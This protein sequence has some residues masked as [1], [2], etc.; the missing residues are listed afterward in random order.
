[1]LLTVP[2]SQLACQA[3]QI[4]KKGFRPS[5]VVTYSFIGLWGNEKAC[6]E[7]ALS[8]WSAANAWTGLNVTFQRV[9]PGSAPA[10]TLVKTFLSGQAAGN[11][12]QPTV[13]AFDG[14]IIG[15]SAQFTTDRSLLESCEG[16][17]KVALHEIGHSMGLADAFGTSGTSVMN[18]MSGKD[19]V[20]NS[21]AANVTSCDANEA[22]AARN[23]P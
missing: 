8:E 15:S 5:T 19:D 20:G 23:F 6:L 16:Y 11:T 14:Y 13:D 3:P 12:P 4:N 17:R 18:Q 22:N 21:I 9:N 10:F 1:M 2:A 7:A